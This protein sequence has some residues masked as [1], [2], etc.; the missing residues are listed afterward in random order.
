MNGQA[1]VFYIGNITIGAIS[2]AS[3]FNIGEN[4]LQDFV[5]HKKHNQGFGTI[6]GKEHRLD[7]LRTLLNDPDQIDML[8]P[9]AR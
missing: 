3:C 6:H 7:N 1:P 4:R 9:G 2:E 5:S 8:V